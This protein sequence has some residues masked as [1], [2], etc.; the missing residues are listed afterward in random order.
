MARTKDRTLIV[1]FVRHNLLTMINYDFRQFNCVKYIAK[2]YRIILFNFGEN[3]NN[4]VKNLILAEHKRYK[5]CRGHK[6]LLHI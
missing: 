2:T 5:I 1:K 3:F 6:M 4:N